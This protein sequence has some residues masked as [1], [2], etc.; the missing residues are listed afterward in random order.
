MREMASTMAIKS[1]LRSAGV[2]RAMARAWKDG[3][4]ESEAVDHQYP[5]QARCKA[6]SH[7]RGYASCCVSGA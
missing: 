2:R 7:G 5:T 4:G 6:R 3:D 1:I